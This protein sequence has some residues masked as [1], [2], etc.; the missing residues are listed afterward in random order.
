M[1]FDTGS[2]LASLLISSVG[3]VLVVYGRR[4]TRLPH[5]L[6]GFVLLVYPYFVPGALLMSAIAAVILGVLWFAVKSGW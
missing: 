3:F 6:A 4:M 5:M 1:G 2:L